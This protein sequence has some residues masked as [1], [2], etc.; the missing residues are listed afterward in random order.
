MMEIP[1][2]R[3]CLSAIYVYLTNKYYFAKKFTEVGITKVIQYL[4]PNE[5]CAHGKPNIRMLQICGALIRRQLS[6]FN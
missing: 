3:Q 1:L 2:C 4:D 5:S 6:I